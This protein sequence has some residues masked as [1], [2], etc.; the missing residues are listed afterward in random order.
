MIIS[1]KHG[2]IFLKTRKTGSSSIQMALSA[3]C[4]DDDIIVGDDGQNVDR[5]IDRAFSRNTHVNLRQLKLAISEEEWQ[6]FFKFAFVRNPWDLVV[7]RYHWEKKGIGC[8]VA[9]FRDWLP[10]YVSSGYA[11]PERNA[12]SNIVQRVWE[13]GGGYI[14]DLQSPFILDKG[15]VDIQFVGRYE[16]LAVDFN[17]VCR[18]VG[19][20]TPALPQ[21]K[22]GFRKF[23][24][25][26]ELYDASSRRLVENAF[27]TDIDQFGYVF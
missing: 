11:E 3:A 9:D 18:V 8:S 23:T 21:L 27:A 17:A 13:A 12:Q 14:N 5:N 6:F 16:K 10:K 1:Y 4:G 25:Y 22:V 26:H 19:I 2:F 15:T 24:E 7:S 20:E